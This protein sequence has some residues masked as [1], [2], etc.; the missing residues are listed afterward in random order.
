MQKD[1][2]FL[3]S[4]DVAII[5]KGRIGLEP[6]AEA[7]KGPARHAQDLSAATGVRLMEEGDEIRLPSVQV[8]IPRDFVE[9]LGCV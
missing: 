5:S 7:Q 3:H 4:R 1:C 9:M 6:V 8:Q 2:Y